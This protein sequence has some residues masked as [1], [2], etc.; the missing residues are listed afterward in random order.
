[1]AIIIGCSTILV[2]LHLSRFCS[3]FG[4]ALDSI[5]SSTSIKDSEAITSSNGVFTL[6]FYSLANSTNRYVGIWY[7]IGSPEDSVIWVANKDKPVKD[8][9]GVV[10]ISEDSNLVVL[11]GKKE[12][13]WSSNVKNQGGNVSARILDT[14]NLVLQNSNSGGVSLWESFQQPSNAFVPN[15]K[16][17]TNTR[18]GEKVQLTSWKSSS[19]PSNGSFYT[20]KE[21]NIHR[22][23]IITVVTG[24]A[25]IAISTYLVWRWKAKHRAVKES[26]ERL[27][28]NK[29]GAH[30]KC[31]SNDTAGDNINE[32][33]L[34]KLPLFKIEELAIATNNFNLSN[35][36]GQGGFGPV[37][38]GTL[39]DGQKVAVK[40][41]SRASGQG[42]KEFMDEVL[43]ISKLQHRNLVRL[44]GCCVEGEEKMLVYEY[45]PN[46][47]LDAFIFDPAKQK[48]LDWKQR[49]NI[50]E[51]IS[52]GL[53]Y[54]HRD[55]RLRIIHR[56]L[57]SSNILLDEEINP[58]I[59]D[60]GM[61]RI[62]GGNENQANT[63]RVVGTYGYMA[64]EYAMSGQFSEKSDVFSYGVL[65]LEIIS[66]RRNT[67]FHDN[68][69]S[70]SLLGYAWQL[71]NENNI[72]AL[73]DK[74]VSDPCHRQELLRCI[75]AGLLCVEES[76]KD[77]PTISAVIS[78]LK[79]EI[80]DLA[81]PKQP[82]FTDRQIASDTESSQNN[83]NR[84]SI[85]DVTVTNVEG[86]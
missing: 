54:L 42:F 22:I 47:S 2:L 35:K 56:D 6:G 24:T 41:L 80:V 20:D 15:M 3:K 37:Y 82:A 11:N 67:S 50:I 29:G 12:I 40:R 17:R 1:M 16:I 36:L 78:M 60:F 49:F 86:R 21:K 58:K 68:E 13:L 51:G 19:D 46:K 73:P 25:V 75:H 74:V 55:S 85:N 26:E 79:S 18:T 23:I 8:D 81:P 48:L 34:Q 38:K 76:A 62:F 4:T 39:K 45:M 72:L 59:S 7:G 28:F 31:F 43:V 61:A 5:I 57:K 32:D 52:R 33:K 14:R 84:C 44:L 63:R 71:W 70:S 10:M 9:S 65:L 64:P 77:R 66:G 69:H 83:Q 53:L 27:V 30:P